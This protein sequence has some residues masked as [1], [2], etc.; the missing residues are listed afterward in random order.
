MLFALY[1]LTTFQSRAVGFESSLG[2]FTDHQDIGSV[3]HAGSATY[4]PKNKTYTV[5]G[6]GANMWGAS[7]AFHFVFKRIDVDTD[8]SITASMHFT[9]SGGDPHKK[10]CLMIRQS[11]DAD[12]A[13]VD[14][15]MHGDGLTSLQYREEKGGRTREIQ[16]NIASPT[17]VSLH[18]QGDYVWMSISQ[19]NEPLSPAGGAFRIKLKSPFYIGLAVC[20]HN[21]EAIETAM[22]KNIEVTQHQDLET[23]GDNQLIESTL[24]IVQISSGDRRVVHHRIGKQRFEAPN[25]SDDDQLVFNDEGS[26][27]QIPVDGNSTPEKIDIASLNRLNNDHGISPDGTSIAISD[28]TKSGGS[29]IYLV[30]RGGGEPK[31][32]VDDAPSYWHG[33]SPDGKTIVYCAQRDNNYDVYAMPSMGGSEVRLT[34]HEGLDDGPEF[35]PDGKYIYFNSV[36]S[37]SMQIWRMKAD[38]SEEVQITDDQFH[39]WFAHPSPDGKWLAFVSYRQQDV[40]PGDH[41]PNKDVEIRLMAIETG[42]IQSLAKLFGGQGTL[43][44]PS[45]S[46]DS[47]RLAFVSYRLMRSPSTP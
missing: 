20:A 21:E 19:K 41:P 42:E 27:F 28:Q 39:N 18:K 43:N 31:L 45:W 46:P 36:R 4:D 14:A 8:C 25:W 33:W 38:G 5:T 12:A 10:A 32:L 2:E 29:R 15:A 16:S 40:A 6:S 34:N 22:F 11:L 9:T 35:S 1:L 7:D 3:K 26:L 47:Q 37:G 23:Q 30:Q 13:Y 17:L 24:E 44:V